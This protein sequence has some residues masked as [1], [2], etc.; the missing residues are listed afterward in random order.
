M[1]D[2]HKCPYWLIW[3]SCHF[4]ALPYGVFDISYKKISQDK[5]L[6]DTLDEYA[7]GGKVTF[8]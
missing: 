5:F 7:P 3:Q 1:S 4:Y 2:A 8:S 6:I